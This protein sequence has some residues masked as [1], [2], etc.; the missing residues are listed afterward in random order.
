[1]LVDHPPN[2]VPALHARRFETIRREC[3]VDEWPQLAAKPARERNAKALLGSIHDGV[4]DATIDQRLQQSFAQEQL[5]R[6]LKR[7][8]EDAMVQQWRPRLQ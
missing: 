6:E 5:R 3:L 1:M 8:L 4:R 2:D 7:E